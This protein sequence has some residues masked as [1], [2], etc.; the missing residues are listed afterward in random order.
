MSNIFSAGEILLPTDHFGAWSVVACDQFTSD[1]SYWASAKNCGEGHPSTLNLIFPEA[2]L[3]N[4][5]FDGRIAAI[6][7]AMEQYLAQGALTHHQNAMV[8]CRRTLASGAV[9]RGI[10]GLLDL[11]CYSYEKGAKPLVRPTEGTVLDR[12]PPRVKIRQNAPLELPHVMVLADDPAKT[13]I[14]PL[15]A[16]TDSMQKVYDFTLM[17]GG[18]SVTG[19]LLTPAQQQ[20]VTALVDGLATGENPLALAVGDGNHSLATARACYDQH[21]GK[22]NRY[23]LVELC[24]LHDDA[25]VFEAIHRAVFDLDVPKFT[26]ALAAYCK[27]LTGR[28]APQEFVLVTTAGQ[29][30]IMVAAPEQNLVVGTVQ[31]FLDDYLAANGGTTDYIHGEKECCALVSNT[32]IAILLP[33]MDKSQLFPTVTK[34]GVLPRKTFSMGEAHDKRYYL[35]AR[36]IRE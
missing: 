34:D 17:L 4:G 31:R 19:W 11:T 12:I 1:K 15:E 18:G 29:Q 24:N 28:C 23:A 13:I 26:A 36:R 5:D 21:P 35:E 30:T 6:N 14:E 33:A 3:N 27:N 9:R 32:S 22:K 10:V 16:E 25:L 20:R 8:Y 2:F 7:A